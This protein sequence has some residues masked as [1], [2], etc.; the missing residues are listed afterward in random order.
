MK[1]FALAGLLFLVFQAVPAQSQELAS[2]S[3]LVQNQAGRGECSAVCPAGFQVLNC[4]HS[5]GA[6]SSGDTCTA[7]ARVFAGGTDANGQPNPQPHDRCSFYAFCASG[8]ETLSVQGWATC[9]KP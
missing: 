1:S 6:L 4:A 5:V 8:S 2:S 7:L 9:Y 3:C